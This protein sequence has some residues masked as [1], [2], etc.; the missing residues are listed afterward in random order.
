MQKTYARSR[1]IK[2]TLKARITRAW[3]QSSIRPLIL[4]PLLVFLVTKTQGI[5]GAQVLAPT[6]NIVYVDRVVEVIREVEVDR[7]F[8]SEKQQIMA[9]IVQVFGEDAPDAIQI[10]K[11]ESGLNPETIGDTNLM[12]HNN[13]ELVGDSIG[14]F[15]VRTGGEGW[16]RA[17]ANEMSAEEF[18]VYLKDYKK[19]ID[20]AKTI[21]DQGGWSP[22][23]NCMNKVL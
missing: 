12:S 22:W 17:K 15:Q 8:K 1:R 5:V 9:Y 3:K 11:C 18:R 13:G 16:N 10:A 19:N 21:F 4:L 20:Y 7:T 14:I 23:Y 6:D 2:H